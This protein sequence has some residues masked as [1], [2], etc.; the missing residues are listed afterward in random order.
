[1]YSFIL[2]HIVASLLFFVVNLKRSKDEAIFKL[3]VTLFIPVFGFLYFL[4]MWVLKGYKKD[5]SKELEDF[6]SYTKDDL[7]KNLVKKI[8]VDKE[9]NIVPVS[10]A[11][12][13]NE[14]QIKRSLLIDIVKENS[15][16][17][18][19][20]LQKA[21]EN[22]DTEISHYA[23][24][25]ITELKNYYITNLQEVSLKYEENKKDIEILKEYVEILKRY[26]N[27]TLLDKRFL[28]K[29]QYTYSEKL[30]ELL[31]LYNSDEKFF[32]DKIKC[33]LDLHNNVVAKEYCDKF[34]NA[35]SEKEEPYLMYMELY[36]NLGDYKSFKTTLDSLK[37]SNIRF[38]NKA[39][40]ITRFWTV[41]D[42]YE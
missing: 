7:K 19:S 3:L 15:E 40:N 34:F 4:A 38:S 23:A 13:L 14:S 17:H 16:E 29:Y 41:G 25:A 42:G 24:T 8:N 32:I 26:M 12:E 9:I 11:L 6:E 2:I 30:G 27:S 1:M 5:N 18:V 36:Y 39:L 31:A 20:I 35:H 21:L 10:E 33:E 28:K 37:N 22:S